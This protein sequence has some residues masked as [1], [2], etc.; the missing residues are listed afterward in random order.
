MPQYHTGEQLV[1]TRNRAVRWLR[2]RIRLLSAN[3]TLPLLIMG[4]QDEVAS[5]P[6]S[7]SALTSQ[8][9]A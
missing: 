1:L 5:R 6:V 2:K 4:Y 9:F 7:E 8:H 3:E